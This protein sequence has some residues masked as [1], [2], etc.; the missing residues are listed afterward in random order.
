[1]DFHQKNAIERLLPIREQFPADMDSNL[2]EV[3]DVGYR[4]YQQ[5]RVNNITEM[6]RWL[7]MKY[8]PLA[9]LAVLIKNYV[10]QVNNGGHIQYYDNGYA[11]LET[12]GCMV[13]HEDTGAHDELVALVK[14]HLTI[15]LQADL[16]KVLEQF[17]IT[18]DT[19]CPDCGG[20]GRDEEECSDCD[21]H[22]EIEVDEDEWEECSACGGSGS[23]ENECFTCGGDGEV[24]NGSI[25]VKDNDKL[26]E[27]LYEFNDELI[28]QIEKFYD[29]IFNGAMV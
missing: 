16:L 15:P 21:G 2:Y 6:N 12:Q 29:D 14:E 27:M 5:K 19:T 8:G 23:I 4:E 10:Y 3:T 24:G 18:E 22:G 20:W 25:H 9:K 17:E 1:M 26:D 7:D 13:D 28:E 11:S